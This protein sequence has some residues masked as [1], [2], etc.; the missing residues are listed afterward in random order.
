MKPSACLPPRHRPK[1]LWRVE[2]AAHVDLHAF[3]PAPYSSGCWRL[4]GGA[5]AR[6]AGRILSEEGAWWGRVERPNAF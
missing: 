5:L 4:L 3:A 6:G 1:E 2:G